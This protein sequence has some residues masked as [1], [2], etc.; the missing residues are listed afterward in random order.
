MFNDNF[1]ETFN[2]KHLKLWIP[3]IAHKHLGH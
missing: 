2:T 3:A 1:N